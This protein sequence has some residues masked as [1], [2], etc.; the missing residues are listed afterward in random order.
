MKTKILLTIAALFVM[1]FVLPAV[2]EAQPGRGKAH[3]VFDRHP[4]EIGLRRARQAKRNAR[5]R[6]RIN[7]RRDRYDRDSDRDRRDR[8][9]RYRDRDDRYYDDDYYDDDYYDRDR[10]SVYDRHRNVINVGIG[11]GAGA[12]VG[13]IVGG[14]KGAL[15]GAGVGAAAGA[16]YTYGINPKDKKRS[17]RYRR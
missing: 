15:I 2:A 9:R 13:G 5:D 16:V 10:R 8:D 3:P 14:K 6:A 17:R 4:G 1:S 7:D 12:V 11:A